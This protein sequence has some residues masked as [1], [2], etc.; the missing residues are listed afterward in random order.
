MANVF[1][2]QVKSAA[3]RLREAELRSRIQKARV[4]VDLLAREKSRLESENCDMVAKKKALA[5]LVEEKSSF[6]MRCF[7][8]LAKEKAHF[9]EWMA[10]FEQ[11]KL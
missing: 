9:R 4:R 10:E 2:R 8:G 7:H 3:T 5:A 11:V 6:L 1:S